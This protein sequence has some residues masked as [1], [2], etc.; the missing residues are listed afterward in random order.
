MSSAVAVEL[1]QAAA[2]LTARGIDAARLEA[3]VLLADALGTDRAH[4]YSERT[5]PEPARTRFA[6]SL[7]RRGRR[8]PLQHIRGRQEFFSRDFA[9]DPR[10]LIPRSETEEV[11]DTVLR[12]L[13]RV[14]R[15]SIL[16]VGTGSGVIAVTLALELRGA[17]VC[18][19]DVSA[20][21]LEVAKA[22]AERL[23]VGDRIAFRRGDLAL[24]FA[25]EPFDAVVSNPPYVPSGELAR[26]APEVR[27]HEP[28]VALDGGPD[29][30]DA[31]RGLA[32]CLADVLTE[33]GELIAEIG[34]GQ[35]AAVRDLFARAA[36]TVVE[37]A[38]DLSGIERV[39]VVR[40][41]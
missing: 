18:A 21:A 11:V 19:T 35:C 13:R 2:L 3:E 36:A 24:P 12:R 8:E 31:Y 22:N 28:R 33:R 20:A 10:V 34:F 15:P 16:D 40:R 17:R 1:E 25:G 5:V 4:L 29:G 27:D 39:V 6:A 9:V 14:E 37:V 41:G 38:H 32:A 26:L 7:D 30:L 23:G